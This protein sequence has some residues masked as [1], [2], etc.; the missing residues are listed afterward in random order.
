[1]AILRPALL[2]HVVSLSPPSPVL[3]FSY[4]R[5]I[6]RTFLDKTF[7]SLTVRFAHLVLCLFF[8]PFSPVRTLHFD[9]VSRFLVD[10]IQQ[11]QQ[12][13]AEYFGHSLKRRHNLAMTCRRCHRH[14]HHRTRHGCSMSTFVKWSSR[15]KGSMK[16]RRHCPLSD[17]WIDD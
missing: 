1:M 15:A 2:S 6:L 9:V 10:S 7:T 11:Q 3:R 12:Q 4:V 16:R 8:C 17:R 14:R 5:L 13:T